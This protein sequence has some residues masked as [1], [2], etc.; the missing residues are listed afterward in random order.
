MDGRRVEL[1]SCD[2]SKANVYVCVP[3]IS[4]ST[5]KA[6]GVYLIALV[7]RHKIKPYPLPLLGGAG[8][9]AVTFGS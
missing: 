8:Q 3:L 4:C 2:T 9:N 6:V 7:S 1:L 5:D